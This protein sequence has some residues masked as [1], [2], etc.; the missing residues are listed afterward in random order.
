MSSC[1]IDNVTANIRCREIYCYSLLILV[2]I[3]LI[4]LPVLKY[5]AINAKMQKKNLWLLNVKM[6]YFTVIFLSLIIIVLWVA[7]EFKYKL[8]YACA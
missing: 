6:D 1:Y 7:L 4:Y 5:T 8:I 3:L 2:Y